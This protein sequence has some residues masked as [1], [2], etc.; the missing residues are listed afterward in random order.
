MLSEADARQ[1]VLNKI[2]SGEANSYNEIYG[3]HTFTSFADHP[4]IAVPIQSGPNA[5]KTSSAA[6]MYQFIGTPW[7]QQAK[8]LGLKDFS[9]DSQDAAAWDLAKTTYLGATGRS[10]VADAQAGNVNWSALG[11]QWESLKGAGAGPGIPGTAMGKRDWT[12]PDTSQNQASAPV[13]P[14]QP[15]PTMAALSAYQAL[16]PLVTPQA[17]TPVA[18]N[19]Q[20]FIPK[21]G[22]SLG[23]EG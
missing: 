21:L 12:P 6:G 16:K 3:G 14:S 9:P 18:Y 2:R 22:G 20:N 17:P 13:P 4:R 19:P 23:L 15:D 7:D 11:G 1:Q 5:G 10:L 8:K